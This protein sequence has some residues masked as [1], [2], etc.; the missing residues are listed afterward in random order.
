M[1]AIVGV[2]P[3]QVH[4]FVRRLGAQSTALRTR[5]LVKALH[6]YGMC[7]IMCG[8]AHILQQCSSYKALVHRTASA[9][10]YYTEKK[11]MR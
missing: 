10:M 1:N 6:M 11:F 5:A 9:C 3:A 4:Q 7:R 8:R 2:S